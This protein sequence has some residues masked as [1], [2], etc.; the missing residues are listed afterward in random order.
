MNSRAILT[1]RDE[2]VGIDAETLPH[3]TDPFFTT[4]YD[5]GGVGLGLSISATIVEE[6]GGTIRFLSE[7]ERGTKVEVK[8]PF[9]F[10][11][12]RQEKRISK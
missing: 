7:P 10:E 11:G 9:T 6:H 5:S 12:N 8:L 3:I 2:G 4:K 1:V